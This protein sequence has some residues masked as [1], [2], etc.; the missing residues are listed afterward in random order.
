MKQI[1][2]RRINVM[3]QC[4]TVLPE[5]FLCCWYNFGLKPRAKGIFNQ[6]NNKARNYYIEIYFLS[7]FRRIE[8]S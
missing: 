8:L 4:N 1:T 2:N 5:S 7:E 6:Y 3:C